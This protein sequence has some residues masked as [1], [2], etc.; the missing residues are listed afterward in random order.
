MT[1][2]KQFLSIINNNSVHKPINIGVPQGSILGPLF[3]VYVNDIYAALSCKPRIRA[4]DTCL[5]LSSP[6][7]SDLE[8]K[9]NIELLNLRIWCDANRLHINPDTSA[10]III[11]PTPNNPMPNLNLLYDNKLIQRKEL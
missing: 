2:R 6:T 10:A 7:L 3:I 5:F 9:C 1:N 4:D 11:P 8:Q